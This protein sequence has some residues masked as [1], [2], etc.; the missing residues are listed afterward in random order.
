MINIKLDNQLAGFSL[1][2]SDPD[3]W[4]DGRGMWITRLLAIVLLSLPAANLAAAGSISLSQSLDKHEIAF[5]DRVTLTLSLSWPG[6]QYAYRFDR[7]L[8]PQLEDFQ[9]GPFSTSISSEGTGDDEVTTKT[10]AYTLIPINYGSVEIEPIAIPYVSYPDSIPGELVSE[11]MTVQVARPVPPQEVADAIATEWI[12]AGILLVLS[13]GAAIVILRLRKSPLTGESFTGPAEEFLDRLHKL[14]TESGSD[15]KKFQTGLFSLL[16]DYLSKEYD[17]A[18]A[19][20]NATQIE[21]EIAKTDMPRE[22]QQRI[23]GWL[24]RAE[25]EKYS[26]VAAAPGETVRLATEIQQYFEENVINIMRRPNG[27]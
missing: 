25:K 17:L 6:P 8:Q 20:K 14:K 26:P 15:V 9:I 23:F 10:F 3:N 5:E 1:I 27:N 4:Y 13:I 12:I 22:R 19:N 11:P 7:P 18:L 21:E 2:R 24:T 16:S